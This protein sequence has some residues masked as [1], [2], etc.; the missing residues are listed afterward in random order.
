MNTRLVESPFIAGE[1]RVATATA[2]ESLAWAWT[3]FEDRCC[4]LSSMQ[5]AIVIELAMRIDRRFPIV[6][7][8]TGYHFVE[9]WEMLK[10][11][12]RT[13]NIEVEVVGPLAERRSDITAGECCDQKPALLDLALADRDAWV[14]GIRRNQ[15]T[16]RADVSVLDRDR[17]GRTKINPLAQWSDQ[18]AARFAR[19]RDLPT[20]PLLDQGYS[21]IGCETCTTRPQKAD[22]RSG[23]WANTDRTECGLH[24]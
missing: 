7:L 1:E 21:S 11:V 4:V 8:D 20:H 14:S 9:T 13:Y 24:L 12:E 17:S 2:L 23:R 5:T 10:A 19:T 18:D 16:N 15:T 22:S 6:F 3:K